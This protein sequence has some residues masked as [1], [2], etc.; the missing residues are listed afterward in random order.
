M[1]SMRNARLARNCIVRTMATTTKSSKQ[2]ET[3]S[4]CIHAQNFVGNAENAVGAKVNDAKRVENV[5]PY[6]EVPGPTPL[7]ILGNTWR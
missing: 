6:S 4:T 5:L 7:P 3:A 1:K 2:L